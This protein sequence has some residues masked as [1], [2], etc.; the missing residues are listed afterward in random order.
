MTTTVRREHGAT[1]VITAAVLPVLILMTA[2]A[3]DLGRQRSSRRTMQARADIVSLDLVRL[4]DGRTEDQITGFDASGGTT[5]ALY[6]AYLQDSADRNGVE[7]IKLAIEWGTW[8]GTT[9]VPTVGN[10][11]P[12]AVQVVASESTD[13]FFRQGSG[14]VTRTA[15]A[16]TDDIAH[17]SLGSTLLQA[18]LGNSTLLNQIL[19]GLLCGGTTNPPAPV[20]ACPR[21]ANV[22]AGGYNGLATHNVTL[23]DLRAAGGYGSV[24]DLMDSSF[25]APQ[26]A[27]LAAQAFRNNGDPTTADLYDNGGNSLAGS[28]T[29]MDGSFTMRDVMAV[30]SPADGAAAAVDVNPFNVFM[31]GLQVANG[32]NFIDLTNAIP[33]LSLPAGISNL[34][35][36]SRYQII[37]SPV[38]GI[39]RVGSASTTNMH[40]A[41]IRLFHSLTFNLNLSV[42]GTGVTGPVTLPVDVSGGGAVGSLTDITCTQPDTSSTIDA[43]TA[44]RVVTGTVG[45]A[46]SV[47]SPA[48]IGSVNLTVAGLPAGSV[49]LSAFGAIGPGAQNTS[50]SSL[51][52]ITIG[53]TR[54]APGSSFALG[55]GL[56]SVE[57]Q[58]GLSVG[59]LNT[60]LATSMNGLLN[61]L[62]VAS[63]PAMEALGLSVSTADVSNIDVDCLAVRLAG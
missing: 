27:T 35:L 55:G 29:G 54:S 30:S 2:F 10:A 4:A 33:A 43:S 19:T 15:I 48:T 22:G 5:P 20:S 45:K 1:L 59:T 41:Q 58:T 53:E 51:P 28:S 40:T 34:T 38:E 47:A 6:A 17:L 12:D 9:F 31:S 37:E 13:Y 62:D 8:N 11:V 52:L 63:R 23:D 46:F 18:D 36:N 42:G 39:G 60:A 24:D 32:N 44:P 16:T 14:S 7:V 26:F 25:T 3:V 50:F 21:S 57:L 49:G 56:T 61:A